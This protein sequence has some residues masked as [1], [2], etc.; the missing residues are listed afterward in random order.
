MFDKNNV[1]DLYKKM[2]S[3]GYFAYQPSNKN[4]I[5]M[6]NMEWIRY[7]DV[8]NYKYKKYETNTVLPFAITGGGDK[9]VFV[10]NKSKEPFVGL[11]YHDTGGGEYYAKN[12]E[13]AI[14]RNII[15]YASRGNF[16]EEIEK[17][18]FYLFEEEIKAEFKNYYKVYEKLICK[19]YLE[20]IEYLSELSLKKYNDEGIERLAFLSY[21]KADM[22]V[23]HYL[24][25]DILDQVFEW[26]PF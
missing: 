20:I 9:W 12:F 26:R 6:D 16:L 21:E 22:M 15:E 17:A 1:P 19:E 7:E 14:L 23:K 5:W 10:D 11:C 25:F 13:D 4:Y 3:L 2:N 8:L 18:D 24:D